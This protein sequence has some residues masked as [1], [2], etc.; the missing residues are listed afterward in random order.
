ML[1][2]LEFIFFFCDIDL[3]SFLVGNLISRK[4]WDLQRQGYIKILWE[5]E[6][7]FRRKKLSFHICA[8]NIFKG[9]FILKTFSMY[10]KSF[11]YY[12]LNYLNISWF[13]H[14][15]CQ[16]VNHIKFDLPFGSVTKSYSTKSYWARGVFCFS[17][18]ICR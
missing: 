14:F 15:F 10:G 9:G 13:Y 16:T 5:F 6:E 3:Y 18:Q 1:I 12:K 4:K 8:R 2:I 7:C 11:I 17:P